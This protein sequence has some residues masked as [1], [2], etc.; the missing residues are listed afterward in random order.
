MK[1]R[2]VILYFVLNGKFEKVYIQ[3]NQRRVFKQLGYLIREKWI[4]CP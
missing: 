3:K 4:L 1:N 2:K